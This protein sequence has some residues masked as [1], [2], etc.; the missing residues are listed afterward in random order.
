ML[1][2]DHEEATAGEHDRDTDIPAFD[3]ETSKTES[4]VWRVV[5]DPFVMEQLQACSDI[6]THLAAVAKETNGTGEEIVNSYEKCIVAAA[7][8]S[9]PSSEV[10]RIAG[11]HF[12]ESGDPVDAMHDTVLDMLSFGQRGKDEITTLP[13]QI[14]PY[15]YID[16]YA[17]RGQITLKSCCVQQSP[18]CK[19]LDRRWSETVV[20]DVETL[21]PFGC[22]QFVLRL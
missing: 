22:N 1:A 15:I 20:A 5:T 13:P 18:R 4:D 8:P 19:L 3:E 10:N 2:E 14:A 21:K 17:H 9:L 11:E 12:S 7:L 16:I 6:D